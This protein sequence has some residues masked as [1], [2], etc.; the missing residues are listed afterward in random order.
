MNS[1][2]KIFK[3]LTL[4]GLAIVGT[5]VYTAYSTS[6]KVKTVAS[7]P[8]VPG[9]VVESA[10]VWE[11]PASPSSSRTQSHSYFYRLRVRTDYMIDGHYFSNTT[12][13]IK[14]IRDQKYLHRDPW[15]NLPD[16]DIIR[17]FKQAPQGTMVPVHYNPGNKAESYIFSELPFWDLYSIPFFVILVGAVFLLLPLGIALHNKLFEKQNRDSAYFLT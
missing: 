10:I 5:G 9:Y 12:P 4:I 8:T 13:G 16:E 17:L 6:E 11:V 15:K 2:W 3:G 14:Q 1:A 7:W